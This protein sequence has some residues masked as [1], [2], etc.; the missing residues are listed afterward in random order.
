MKKIKISCYCLY[1]NDKPVFQQE[2]IIKNTGIDIL[3]FIKKCD[4]NFDDEEIYLP[5]SD[6]SW[7]GFVSGKY[8]TLEYYLK[9]NLK[10]E[11]FP[12]GYAFEI[13][14]DYE[15]INEIDFQIEELKE[16]KEKLIEDFKKTP[17]EMAIE[18]LKDTP[19]I[20]EDYYKAEDFLTEY[21]KGN[22]PQKPKFSSIRY[23]AVIEDIQNKLIENF[24]YANHEELHE[25][26]LQVLNKLDIK[27]YLNCIDQ[28]ILD[29]KTNK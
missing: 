6:D 11:G 9:D 28:V 21:L 17:Q 1:E 13:K 18:L 12:T 16:K 27:S 14:Q 29:F 5:I 19:L 15:A 23:Y 7:N 24:V 3:M 4:D 22:D 8:D 26:A 20:N 25:L 2:C 10:K